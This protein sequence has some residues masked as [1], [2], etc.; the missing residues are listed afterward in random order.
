MT[1]P[2]EGF[3]CTDYPPTALTA[4]Q[5]LALFS[6]QGK[7]FVGHVREDGITT[8]GQQQRLTVSTADK[9]L[10]G[11]NH[12]NALSKKRCPSCMMCHF[13]GL[14]TLKDKCHLPSCTLPSMLG[15]I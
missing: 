11:Q 14:A 15:L 3:T 5:E 4:A 8:K 10:L 2:S 6:K 12:V 1:C 13:E 7:S 9:E